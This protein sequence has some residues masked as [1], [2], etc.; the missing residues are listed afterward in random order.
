LKHR[1]TAPEPL[2]SL[3]IPT[4][5]KPDLLRTCLD[6][7]RAKTT[8]GNYEI[9]VVDNNSE[10]A[11]TFVYFEEL[12]RDGRVRVVPYPHPFNYSG[13]NNAAVRLA[14]GSIIGLV[15]NDIEVISP[16]WL[17]EM[18]SW[19]QQPGIGCVGA[20]LLY[21]DDTVQ[22]AGVILGIGGVA[23]HSHKMS[24]RNAHGYFSRLKVAQTLSAVTAACMLV[25]KSI[26]AEVR[27]MDS[28]NLKVAFNDVDFCLK[29]RSAGYR[30]VWTPFAELY[31]HE[32]KSRGIE[33]TPEKQERFRREVET[34]LVRWGHNLR[35]DPY[36][37]QH[38][39]QTHEDF[40]LRSEI[41]NA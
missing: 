16:D 29:V 24:P 11:E 17:T 25:R 22:H 33:D 7:I 41:A 31:H 10:E 35:N 13:I 32:S 12:A 34:M 21:P 2:V 18:V 4:R 40:S 26:Y 36:Y 23:G 20:K 3:I 30:N 38:L 14:R 6:S 15:N 39:T 8:Y 1:V 37:S 19:A 28:E 9:L 5:D 27:G